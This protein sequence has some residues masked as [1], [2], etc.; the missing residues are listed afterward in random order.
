MARLTRKVINETLVELNTALGTP[1]E[2]FS[3]TANGEMTA[4][5]GHIS[6]YEKDG[7]YR[8]MQHAADGSMKP[9]V[10][11]DE[12]GP[13]ELVSHIRGIITGIMLAKET[14]EE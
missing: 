9:L 12:L 11:V 4:N 13:H 7:K 10:F 3:T 1:T 14:E 5:S 6:V 2:L 8:L